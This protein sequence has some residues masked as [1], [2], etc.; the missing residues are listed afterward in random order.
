[1]SLATETAIM[2]KYKSPL[3]LNRTLMN[4]SS[5]VDETDVINKASTCDIVHSLFRLESHKICTKSEERIAH[6]S[7]ARLT[8]NSPRSDTWKE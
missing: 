2:D 5:L 7:R 8:I 4:N 1:M 3:L 6:Y